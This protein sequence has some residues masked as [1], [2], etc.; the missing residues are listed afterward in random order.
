VLEPFFKVYH[1]PIFMRLGLMLPVDAPLGPP[2]KQGWGVR[3][4]LGWSLD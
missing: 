2:L 4:T 3:G 1:D